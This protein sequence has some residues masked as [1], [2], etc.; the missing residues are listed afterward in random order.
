MSITRRVVARHLVALLDAG[1]STFTEGGLKIHR[2]SDNLQITDMANA[3]KR[4]KKVR[5]LYVGTGYLPDAENDKILKDAVTQI[6][7]MSYD[8][9]KLHLEKMPGLRVEEKELRGVD[10]EPMGT[11]INLEKKFPNGGEVRIQASP[12]SFQ[13]VDSQPIN[14]PGKPAHGFHQDTSY[15]PSKKQDAIIFY[16]WLKENTSKAGNMTMSELR[17][18]WHHLGVRYDSH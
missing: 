16:G 9:A 5:Q 3:G 12:H 10:V 14:S 18:V 13:V 2:Y 4:G 7:H 17:E 8:N 11:T 15:W 1:R 6:I